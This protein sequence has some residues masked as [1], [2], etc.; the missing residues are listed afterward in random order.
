M[1]TET[2]LGTYNLSETKSTLIPQNENWKWRKMIQ[3]SIWK[4][5]GAEKVGFLSFY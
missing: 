3:L 2:K 1:N 4:Q 5:I